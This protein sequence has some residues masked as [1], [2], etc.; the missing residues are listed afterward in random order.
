MIKKRFY[1]YIIIVLVS[2]LMPAACSSPS[3][4]AEDAPAAETAPQAESEPAAQP[5][6]PATEEADEPAEEGVPTSPADSPTS[7][8]E[9][10]EALDGLDSCLFGSWTVDNDSM[11]AYLENALNSNGENEIFRIEEITGRMALAFNDAGQMT[12]SSE[13][14]IIQVIAAFSEQVSMDLEMTLVAEGTAEYQADGTH[15]TNKFDDF[16]VVGG[17]LDGVLTAAGDG[18][19]SILIEVTPDWFL[20]SAAAT[21]GDD[22]GA[23]VYSCSDT[24]LSL[25]TNAYGAVSLTRD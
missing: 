18:G 9:S 2:G 7:G 23:G 22:S 24:A 13:D 3:N 8:P 25:Q 12:V 11:A 20:A 5:A 14:Y 4:A 10:A 15:L 17:P 1:L 19:R 6:A 21:A 16:E